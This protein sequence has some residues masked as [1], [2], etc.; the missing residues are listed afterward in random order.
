MLR[1]HQNQHFTS[2]IYQLNQMELSFLESIDRLGLQKDDG[3]VW[4]YF[5]LLEILF[6]FQFTYR[7]EEIVC[8]V[9]KKRFRISTD[10]FIRWYVGKLCVRRS[11]WYLSVSVKLKL[12]IDVL[13]QESNKLL[14]N[15]GVLKLSDLR[16]CSNGLM[17]EKRP[18]RI[19]P[20]SVLDL[21]TIFF[22]RITY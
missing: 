3:V 8:F 10:S 5:P 14:W 19:A 7:I 11:H 1:Q 6:P 13:R 2:V 20:A 4:V 9:Q 18:N 22:S 17:L 16:R 15:E 21:H 12:D